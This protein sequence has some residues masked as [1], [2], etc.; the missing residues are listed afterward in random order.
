MRIMY[1]DNYL[2]YNI[3]KYDYDRLNSRL[4][5]GGLQAFDPDE[6][7]FEK[8]VKRKK[9]KPS[10]IPFRE[11]SK[12]IKEKPVK[13]V[14]VITNNIGLKF[15]YFELEQA[16]VSLAGLQGY[17]PS[18]N[19]AIDKFD[20]PYKNEELSDIF[21]LKYKGFINVPE[22]DVYTFSVLSN[23]GSHL[24]IADE[25]LVDNDGL[26]G[27]FEVVGEIALQKGWH[28]IELSYFQAGGGKD[29]KVYWT[30]S[31]FERKEISAENLSCY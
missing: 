29:L 8:L 5:G 6:I 26:H 23:D 22:E 18:K 31:E 24:F 21:G 25:L 28:K 19:G 3:N 17:E 9:Q 16:L 2:L 13:P 11:L 27:A 14:S 4:E 12:V 15:E 7:S 10:H 20:F 1:M 30:N